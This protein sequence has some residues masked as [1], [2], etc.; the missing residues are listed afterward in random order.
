MVVHK[1]L[2][3]RNT[4]PRLSIDLGPPCFLQPNKSDVPHKCWLSGWQVSSFQLSHPA[5]RLRPFL[6]QAG[7]P[8]LPS[9]WLPFPLTLLTGKT[10]L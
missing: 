1:P 3:S 5:P 7:S 8:P 10:Q 6:A 2:K 9:C 4:A